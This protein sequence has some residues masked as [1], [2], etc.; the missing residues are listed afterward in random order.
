MQVGF[1]VSRQTGTR[2]LPLDSARQTHSNGVLHA[3][4]R[5]LCAAQSSPKVGAG[6]SYPKLTLDFLTFLVVAPAGG[7]RHR[8]DIYHSIGNPEGYPAVYVAYRALL[9]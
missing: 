5:P 3:R 9:M 2:V 8:R 4:V 1:L 7:G 6:E